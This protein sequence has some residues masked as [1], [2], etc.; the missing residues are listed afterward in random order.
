MP[1]ANFA[2]SDSFEVQASDTVDT[3]TIMV[4]V[5]VAP[6]NDAP[7]LDGS[8]PFTIPDIAEDATNPPGTTCTGEADT[9]IERDADPFSRCDL[10]SEAEST[11]GI[12]ITHLSLIHAIL[13]E[14]MAKSPETQHG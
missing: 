11:V 10:P 4:T 1:A 3:S 5:N 8:S 7:I 2:G 13:E 6:V 14:R 9:L 12:E